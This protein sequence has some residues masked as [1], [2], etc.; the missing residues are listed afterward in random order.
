[1]IDSNFP[2]PR[3]AA[4]TIEKAINN[5]RFAKIE[6]IYI[7][8]NGKQIRRFIGT[9]KQVSIDEK[10]LFEIENNVIIHNH[11]S[12][13]S[14]SVEDLKTIIKY[15]TKSLILV[16]NEFLFTV[17]RPE[18]GWSIDFNY[19]KTNKILN[20][21][22]TTAINMFDKLISKNEITNFEKEKDLF[23]YIWLL[24]FQLYEI[25]YKKTSI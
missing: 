21:C 18:N 5:I 14:F 15:N 24:F 13:S 12:G 23:H 20:S 9:E 25:V 1:M 2:A 7:F 19:I 22:Y 3:D 4:N 6:Y 10:Y 16:T 8:K 11:P 17:N